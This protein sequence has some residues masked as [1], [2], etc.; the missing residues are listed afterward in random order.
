MSLPQIQIVMR[1]VTDSQEVA[2]ACAQH[3][4][5]KRNLT[6]LN[7]HFKEVY[8]RHRGKFICVAGE[9]LFVADTP[10]K[11]I[12]LAKAAHP[13]DDGRLIRYIYPRKI[14]RIYANQWRVD[15]V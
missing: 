2:M 4:R 1:E 6:W 10:K 15:A 11:V 12:A 7:A 8:T 5:Y 3:E 14:A 13:E 9:K